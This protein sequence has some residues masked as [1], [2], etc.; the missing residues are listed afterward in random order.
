MSLSMSTCSL[1]GTP[2]H[3]PFILVCQQHFMYKMILAFP[4][5]YTMSMQ[6]KFD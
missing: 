6:A 3:L 5:I 1:D 4:C 2:Q